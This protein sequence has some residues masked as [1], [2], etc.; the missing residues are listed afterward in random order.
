MPPVVH[1]TT[2]QTTPSEGTTRLKKSAKANLVNYLLS[3]NDSKLNAKDAVDEYFG[4]E[5]DHRS[6]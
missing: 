4:G 5:V 3:K 1:W 6:V 2:S